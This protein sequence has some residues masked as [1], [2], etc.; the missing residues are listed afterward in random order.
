M[1][2]QLKFTVDSSLAKKF[3]AEVLRRRGKLDLSHEGA[4][5][6]RLYLENAPGSNNPDDDPLLK[7]I[8]IGASRGKERPNALKDKRRLYEA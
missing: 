3:K 1:P 6:L 4:E 5:A 2:T 7:V 8:G